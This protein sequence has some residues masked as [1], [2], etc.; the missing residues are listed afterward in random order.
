ME[1]D[2]PRKDK[3][4][5]VLLVGKW[6]LEV[7]M[8]DR[9]LSD[10]ALAAKIEEICGKRPHVRT[11]QNWRRA[12]DRPEMILKYWEAL[13]QALNC[14]HDDLVGAPMT[15]E[16]IDSLAIKLLDDRPCS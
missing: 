3:M 10:G 12:S 16:D 7:L 8:R 15:R 2:L 1:N 11:V 5:A 14:T 9:R 4:R 13:P 6:N